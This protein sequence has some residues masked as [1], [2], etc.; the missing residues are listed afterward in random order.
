[1]EHR[2]IGIREYQFSG[3]AAA[4]DAMGR[5]MRREGTSHNPKRAEHTRRRLAKL[6]E[7]RVSHNDTG[8]V[9]I[10]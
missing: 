10:G 6:Q 3:V 8:R 5:V 9:A 2:P 4:T 1:M 7:Q